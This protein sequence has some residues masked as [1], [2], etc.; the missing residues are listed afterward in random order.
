M[1][2]TIL[3]LIYITLFGFGYAQSWNQITVP[4]AEHLI[5]IEFPEG[6]AGVGYI[7]GDN[8]VLLKTIDG[9][10]SW[11]SVDYS[12]IDSSEFLTLKFIDLEFVSDEGTGNGVM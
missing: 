3:T 7:G 2:R 5:D 9:G 1:N 8:L 4:T 11:F 12:G 6:T 10:L